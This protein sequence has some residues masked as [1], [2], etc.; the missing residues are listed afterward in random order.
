M[1][2]W[3]NDE[4][5]IIIKETLL[6]NFEVTD[7]IWNQHKNNNYLDQDISDDIIKEHLQSCD[8]YQV[9]QI[10]KV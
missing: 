3:M 7:V 2:H 10:D 8:T 4:R 9:N 5:I 1:P 6:K